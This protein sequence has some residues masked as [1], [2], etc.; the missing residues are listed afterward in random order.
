MIDTGGSDVGLKK[1]KKKKTWLL[2]RRRLHRCIDIDDGFVSE[3][4]RSQAGSRDV[5]T[6]IIYHDCGCE[7]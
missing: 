3:R 4:P 6:A 2:R 1:K 5:G 7:H